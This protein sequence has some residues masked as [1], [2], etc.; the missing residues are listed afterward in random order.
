LQTFIH[1]ATT[2]MIG[3]AY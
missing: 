3:I 1:I 2:K